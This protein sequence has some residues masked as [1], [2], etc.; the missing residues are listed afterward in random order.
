VDHRNSSASIVQRIS[1]LWHQYLDI[2]EAAPWES[3]KVATEG[4]TQEVGVNPNWWVGEVKKKKGQLCLVGALYLFLRHEKSSISGGFCWQQH[5][6]VNDSLDEPGLTWW[7]HIWWFRLSGLT[8][9]VVAIFI[10]ANQ[11]IS[12]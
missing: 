2:W 5:S 12:L 1:Q 4:N 8:C 10:S 6:H 3:Y 11:L 9:T 7:F